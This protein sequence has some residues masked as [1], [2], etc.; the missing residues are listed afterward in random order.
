MSGICVVWRKQNPEPALPAVK[1]VCGAL[2]MEASEQQTIEVDGNM[3]VGVSARFRNQQIHRSPA[4]LVVCDADLYNEAE[5]RSLVDVALPETGQ[6]AALLGGLYERF[7]AGCAEK[8]A[9]TFSVIIADRRLRTIFAATDGFGIPPLVYHDDARLLVVASRIDAVLG[10][11]GVPRDINPR[12]IA[13]Y[14][15]YTVNLAPDTIFSEVRRLLPGHFLL[16]SDA[17]CRTQRYWDMQYNFA[18]GADE[19]SLSLKLES[20]V[21]QSVRTHCKQEEEFL[22]LGAYLSGGTDSSTVVG[23]MS[24]LDRGPVHT[25][26]IGFEDQRFNELEYA[27]ITARKFQTRHHEYLVSAADCVEAVPK[28][29]R[30]YDEPFGNSSAI[31]TYFCAALAA[32][33]GVEVLLG[34]DGGDELFAGNERYLTDKVFEVYQKVP[35]L[36]RKGIIEPALAA[37]PFRNGLTS[38]ARRYIRRSNFPQPYRFFSYN[39]MLEDGPAEVFEQEFLDQLKG[40]SVLETP[41]EYYRNGPAR[42]H[43]NRLL[44]ID[45]KMTLSDNDL[46]KVT[47][48]SELAG[49]RSRFPFLDRAVAE[50]SGTIPPHLKVKG[51][52]KRY[53]FKRAFRQLLPSEVIRKTKH[54]FGIPVAYWMKSDKRMREIAQDVL[55]SPRTFER[56]YIRRDYIEELFRRHEEDET[57]FYGDMLWIFLMLELLFRQFVD[58]PVGAAA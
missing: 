21:E 39:P 49:I 26:S 57:P 17:Q 14:L 47:R 41:S 34:G 16:A 33:N 43:L 46:L 35:R 48:M 1:S 19:R 52:E 4:L 28:I 50:F 53:L 55:R 23:M 18:R 37:I 6:T 32:Q 12:G 9:G 5:L 40:Y 11:G 51:T 58:E 44:Y 42:D 25:F 10:C 29:V 27:R 38:K 36:L 8:L 13:K 3:G 45:V 15:T 22:R 24:R 7:G 56:G 20:L 2:S 30:M 31:P 54:G